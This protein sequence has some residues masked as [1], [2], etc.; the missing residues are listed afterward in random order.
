MNQITARRTAAGSS[1]SGSDSLT[2]DEDFDSPDARRLPRRNAGDG[3]VR[4]RRLPSPVRDREVFRISKHD[5]QTRPI[6]HHLRD[7]IEAHL[8]IVF[9]ALAASRWIEEATGWSVRKLVRTARLYRTIEIQAGAH[10]IT[11]ADPLPGDLRD[12][13]DRIHG[14]CSGAH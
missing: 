10:S 13:L 12:A 2:V 11:A 3:R 9:A 6:Y 7:S 1:G 14:R 5:L 4:D 8:P